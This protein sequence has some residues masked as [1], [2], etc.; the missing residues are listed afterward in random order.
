MIYSVR[1]IDFNQLAV[2]PVIGDQR[3]S[4]LEV[5]LDP[6]LYRFFLIIITLIKL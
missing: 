3:R 2:T 4:L 6:V 5:D 1:S